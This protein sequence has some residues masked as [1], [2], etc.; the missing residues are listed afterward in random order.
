M[1]KNGNKMKNEASKVACFA[2]YSR[3]YEAI[4]S[5]ART[6]NAPLCIVALMCLTMFA[7][8]GEEDI[9]RPNEE[10][11]TIN[12]GESGSWTAFRGENSVMFSNSNSSVISV[13]DNGTTITFTG[14]KEG[15]SIITAKIDDKLAFANVTVKSGGGGSEDNPGGTTD[16][17]PTTDPDYSK[18]IVMN[19]YYSG[20]LKKEHD[21]VIYDKKTRA[22]ETIDFIYKSKVFI[23]TGL[24]QEILD[25]K[26]GN[27]DIWFSI[28]TTES[29][30]LNDGY[31]SAKY[32][33][34]S[35]DQDGYAITEA[36]S[37]C[38]ESENNCIITI[39]YNKYRNKY[40]MSISAYFFSYTCPYNGTTKFSQGTVKPWTADVGRT[41]PQVYENNFDNDGK[42]LNDI[43]FIYF[44][45]KKTDVDGLMSV[46]QN[47]DWSIK[48][49]ASGEL[50]YG[51][52]DATINI[53]KT[54]LKADVLIGK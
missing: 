42:L 44:D 27:P 3:L 39:Y 49:T 33:Y 4:C 8:C 12:V 23:S 14:L 47:K 46:S 25:G 18:T 32:Y 43:N 11:F 52:E 29:F 34:K 51:K 37:E 7:T 54:H 28:M 6:V 16:P 24:W 30:E 21:E 13:S 38:S 35:T 17:P 1:K 36:T 53:Y 15:K 9:D 20:T 26:L 5:F 48:L 19:A 50:D 41:L 22:E 45:L 31:I 2:V 40:R 10:E